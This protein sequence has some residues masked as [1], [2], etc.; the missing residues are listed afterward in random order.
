M[1]QLNAQ[2]S[3]ALFLQRKIFQL[4]GFPRF[5]ELYLEEAAC[6]FLSISFTLVL[7]AAGSR[8]VAV[9]Q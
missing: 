4:D 2:E 1:S 3:F 6:R 5:K 7:M 9:D 8:V